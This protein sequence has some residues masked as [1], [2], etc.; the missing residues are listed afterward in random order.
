MHPKNAALKRAKY[1]NVYNQQYKEKFSNRTQYG[2]MH[3][4]DILSC[5][6]RLQNLQRNCQGNDFLTWSNLDHITNM[7]DAVI[8][9]ADERQ[10]ECAKKYGNKYILIDSTF[11]IAKRL[12]KLKLTAVMVMNELG[13]GVTVCYFISRMM[14][15]KIWEECLTEFKNKLGAVLTPE[16][17]MSDDDSSYYNAWCKIMGPPKRKLLCT[18]HVTKAWR[19]QLSKKV[20]PREKKVM[21]AQLYKLKDCATV[22]MFNSKYRSMIKSWMSGTVTQRAAANY[23]NTYYYKRRKQ[24]ADCYRKKIGLTTNNYVE[25]FFGNLKT[26]IAKTRERVDVLIHEL[27]RN[28]EYDRKKYDEMI[29]ERKGFKHRVHVNLHNKALKSTETCVNLTRKVWLVSDKSKSFKVTMGNC[30][31]CNCLDKC[32]HCLACSKRFNC[33]CK[34]NRINNLVCKHIHSVCIKDRV[35]KGELRSNNNVCNPKQAKPQPLQYSNHL[36]SIALDNPEIYKH[37]NH[38]M[39]NYLNDIFKS[40]N[41]KDHKAVHFKLSNFLVTLHR[42]NCDIPQFIPDRNPEPTQ[43]RYQN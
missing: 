33:D 8:V 12:H 21:M 17:F 3:K 19:K 32:I 16:V 25:S 40:D 23:F 18:W 11:N 10:I 31:E 42:I 1:K 20:T 35:L 30:I 38:E 29:R 15:D 36:L 2:M 4:I 14:N 24:W 13:V 22:S 9:L 5:R 26:N 7:R 43:I 27:L 39:L 6:L 37:E 34:L 28:S 41:I